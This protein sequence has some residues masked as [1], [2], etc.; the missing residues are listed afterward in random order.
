MKKILATLAII[1]S[2]MTA[3]I[4]QPRAV[5]AR[6]GGDVEVSY[7]HTVG[8]NNMLDLSAGIGFGKYSFI[9]VTGMYDWLFPINQWNYAGNWTFYA[10][11]GV[12][13]YGRVYSDGGS[14]FALSIGGQAGIEYAFDFPLNLSIDWRPMINLLGL[15]SDLGGWG[16]L[17]G[18]SLG[19]RYRF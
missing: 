19:V 16:H 14:T 17:S 11:P 1:L 6:L 13:L 5:G 15:G 18:I 7:Q 10:G 9:G 4:A 12:G 3:A 8:Y 2:V